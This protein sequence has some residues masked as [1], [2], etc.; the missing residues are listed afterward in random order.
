MGL[1]LLILWPIR[2]KGHHKGRSDIR[3]YK[4]I[5]SLC[6]AEN[7]RKASVKKRLL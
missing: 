2:W 3:Y 4:D 5:P 6:R 1:F 7:S